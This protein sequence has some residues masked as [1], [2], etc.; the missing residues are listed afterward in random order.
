MK[1]AKL[2]AFPV[3]LSIF[4][5]FLFCKSYAV[6]T[7]KPGETLRGNQTLVSPRGVFELGFFPNGKV[8]KQ[9]LGIWLKNDKYK[10]AVWVANQDSALVDNSAVLYIRD[11]GNLVMSDIRGIPIVVNNGRAAPSSNTSCK[12]L[13]SGN[14]VLMEGEKMFWQSFD[15]P[16]DTYLPG[17]KLGWFNLDTD[18]IRKQFLVSWSTPLDPTK[19]NFFFGIDTK[20]VSHFRIWRS[21]DNKSQPIG[22]WNGQKLSF[23]FQTKSKD[24]NFSF[25]SNRKE[26]YFTFTNK[27]NTSVPSTWFELAPNG[28]INELTMVGKEISIINHPP[29][30]EGLE[31]NSTECLTLL[32]PLCWN[33]D[34][35]SQIK[36]T[37]PNSMTVNF[38]ARMG[39]SDCEITCKSNCSCTAYASYDSKM[40]SLYYGYMKDLQ[41]LGSGNHSIYLR[42]DG[43]IESSKFSL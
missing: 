3:L 2:L 22:F 17:M 1:I 14:L 6:Y 38:P 42:G 16:T 9:Y 25:V 18:H 39:L 4:S 23:Y 28:D 10:K 5:C 27:E 11:D 29:C 36:G 31:A 21:L 30:K 24:Y 33:G 43:Q 20:S 13:D 19:G 8:P 32:P 41:T 37:I 15:S 26:I 12:L 7:L 40:C 35:F 34:K